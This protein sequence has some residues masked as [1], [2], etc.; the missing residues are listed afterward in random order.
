MTAGMNMWQLRSIDGLTGSPPKTADQ[1]FTI[2]DD[3]NCHIRARTLYNAPAV[4]R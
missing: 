2:M 1:N 3:K 4:S